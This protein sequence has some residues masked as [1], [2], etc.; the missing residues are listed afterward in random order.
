MTEA[1]IRG[2]Y[3]SDLTGFFDTDAYS[4]EA[5]DFGYTIFCVN[6]DRGEY[7]SGINETDF[8]DIKK[9]MNNFMCDY[10]ENYHISKILK[11]YGIID[12][13]ENRRKTKELF[14]ITGVE[15]IVGF[16]EIKTGKRWNVKECRGYCQ[17]DYTEVIYCIDFYDTHSIDVIGDMYLGCGKEFSI[18]FLDEQEK[19]TDTICGY[20]VADSEAWKDEDIKKIVCEYEGLNPDNVTLELVDGVTYTTNISY[21][22]A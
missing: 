5:G 9:E 4:K 8:E 19:E 1:I 11:D 12:N 14:E 13:P 20:Y 18:T 6:Y 15:K 2:V 21:R 17:G 22:T 3:Q 7:T 16:L 10:E